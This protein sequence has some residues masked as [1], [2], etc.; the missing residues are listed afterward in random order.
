M[1]KLMNKVFK[2]KHLVLLISLT[3]IFNMLEVTSLISSELKSPNIWNY[4]MFENLIKSSLFW[5]NELLKLI[6][7]VITIILNYIMIT[8]VVNKVKSVLN[9]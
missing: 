2:T 4:Y 9:K 7:I 6:G 8:L 3:I 1:K 5:E